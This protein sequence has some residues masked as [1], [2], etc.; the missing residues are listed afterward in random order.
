M[1]S[2]EK[3]AEERKAHAEYCRKWRMKRLK[4]HYTEKK[5][6]DI[7]ME[8]IRELNTFSVLYQSFRCR[9]NPA[10]VH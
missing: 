1:P 10:R 9:V 8:Y 4:E 2:K 5:N 6:N 7:R 3:T